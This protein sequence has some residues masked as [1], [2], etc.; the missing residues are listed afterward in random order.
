M[1]TTLDWYGCATFRMRTAGLTIFLDAYIDRADGAAGPKDDAGRPVTA[2]SVTECDWIVVGHSHFDHLYGAERIMANT[3]ATLIGSY[4]SVRVMEQ[5]G[6]PLD[7]M[8]CVAGGE[9]IDLGAGVTVRVYP[10]QHSCVW[11]H[12]SMDQPDAVCLGDLGVTWQE[13]KDRFR[14]LGQHLAGLGAAVGDHLRTSQPGHSDRGDGGALVY[15]F[16]TPDGSLFYQDTSGH[17]SGVLHDLRPDVALLG[18]AGR[19]NIDGQP[20]Q[21]SLAQFV[22]R[23][24]DLLRP[25]IVV[26]TH[27]D[28]WLPGFSVATDVEPI[29][30]EL[31]RV[32]P[33]T[34]LV[35]IGYL[36]GREILPR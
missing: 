21:G 29:R 23:Q 26:L 17:W 14:Q 28:D 1:T 25:G 16:E 13:Q 32:V 6:V 30:A 18:A 11:S 9:T 20:I 15:L 10:S 19:G 36:D 2:D 12:S 31:A 33:R 35:E 7:R 3:D 5:A 24:A 8:I 27:H 4:E 34:E 22:A